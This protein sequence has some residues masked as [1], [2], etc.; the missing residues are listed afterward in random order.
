MTGGYVYRGTAEPLLAGRYLFGDLCSGRIWAL[1]PRRRRLAMQRAAGYDDRDHDIR[2]GRDR[3]TLLT[4][5]FQGIVYRLTT[6]ERSSGPGSAPTSRWR[7]A[8][9]THL[10][11]G[12]GAEH[13][14]AYRDR[15][16]EAPG[17]TRIVQYFDKSAWRSPNPDADPTAIWYVT[18]GLLVVELVTGRMQLGDD[19]FEQRAPAAGQ[20]GRRSRRPERPDLRDVRHAAATPRRCRTARRSPS[21]S[22][23]AGHVTDDPALA[24]YGVTAAQRVSVPGI[25]HQVASPFWEF[26]NS[27]GTVYWRTAAIVEG[28]LFDN[29]FYATGYPITE[30][31]WATSRW[32]DD[33]AVLMQCFERRC[34][35]YTPGNPDGWQVE[36]GNV[37]QH[38]YHWRYPAAAEVAGVQVAA[39]SYSGVEGVSVRTRL[40]VGL[41]A[42]VTLVFAIRPLLLPARLE[43]RIGCSRRPRR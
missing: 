13:R 17:G 8:R 16:L 34:L 37:G 6:S 38:Y 35:T 28:P 15:M 41:A 11:V 5:I 43:A 39:K 12:A 21:A 31:Y 40:Q 10:D 26:M 32:R 29:P 27:S 42:A 1:R 25:D 30:A 20:R 19:S 3:R 36:A 22:T 24:A 4:D 9:L 7:P 23:A 2:R 33:A 18:N 14:R